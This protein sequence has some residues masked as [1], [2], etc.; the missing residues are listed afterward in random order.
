[1]KKKWPFI[2]I[3]DYPLFIIDGDRGTNYPAKED[4]LEMGF[5]VFLN[6]GNVTSNGFDFKSCSFITEKNTNSLEK[7]CSKGMTLF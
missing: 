4:F 7:A 3:K 1:M 5:C 2:K 6:T